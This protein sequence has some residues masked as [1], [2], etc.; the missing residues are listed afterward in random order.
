MKHIFIRT[1]KMILC[2]AL[3][4]PAHRLFAQQATTEITGTV[5]NEKKEVVSDVTVRIEQ[6][7]TFLNTTTNTAGVFVMHG[8][9]PGVAYNLTFS[10]VGYAPKLVAGFIAKPNEKNSILIQMSQIAKSLDEMVIVGYSSQKKVDLTGAV[11][12]VSG[13]VLADRPMPNVARGLQG[14]IPNLNITITD[15]K[16]IRS[17][18]F[19]VRGITS[20]NG[21]SALVL[22][23]G[24]SGDPSLLNP[25]DIESIS[26]LKDAASAAIYGARGS[27][28][29]VLIT[30]KNPKKGKVQVNFN[31]SYTVNQKT[32]DPKLV[33]DGYQWAQAFANAY[34]GWYDYKSSPTTI[35][36][37]LPFPNYYL[38]SLKARSLDP[39]LPKVGIDPATGK[40]IYYGST[41]WYHELY[42]NN[43]YGLDNAISITGSG[44]NSSFLISGRA[45]SQGGIFRYNTDNFD[46]YNLRVKGD[47]NIRPWLTLSDNL[48]FNSYKYT[49]PVPNNGVPV[50]RMMDLS[51]FPVGVM[52]NPDGTLTPSSYQTVGDLST[53]NN[54]TVTKQFYLR[55]T[56]SFKADIIKN[57]LNLK[58]DFTYAYTNNTVDGKYYPVSY[59]PAP[60]VY[61]AS[62]NSSLNKTTG[63]TKYYAANL[64]A[65]AKKR[66]G[67]HNVKLLGGVNIEDSRYETNFVQRDGVLD[68]SL[69]DFSLLN[70][71]NYQVSGGGNEWAVAGF[72]FRGNYDYKDKYLLEVN[73]RYDGSS[74]FPGYSQ[75]GFF[76]SLSL[77]W[78]L[79]RESFM[80]FTSN[81]LDN[82]KL[83]ASVGSLGNGQIPPYKFIQTMGVSQ[84]NNVVLNGAYP[85]YTRMPSVLPTGLTWETST[86]YDAGID[87]SVL[88]DRLSASFD[89]Y[90]RNTTGMFTP[91]Q[92]LPGVFGAGV[93]N[94]NFSDLKTLGWELSLNWKDN[95]NDDLGYSVGVVLSDYKAY[96]TRYNN[97]NGLIPYGNNSNVFYKGQ[98]YGEIWGFAVDGLFTQAQL[99]KAH[100][101]QSYFIVSN[102]NTLMP[103]DLKFKDLNGD[104]AINIGQGTLADHGD[105]KVIGN[106]LPRYAYGINLGM[107][108]KGFAFNA[109]IQGIGHRD[110]WPGADEGNFW[111]Q[112]N[113]TY[114]QV[115]AYMMKNVWSPENPNAYFPRYRGYV[116]QL[117]TRE[118]TPP[119]DRYMQNA[120]YMRLKNLNISWTLPKKW[121]TRASITNARIYISGQ[122]LFTLTPL[123]KYAANIDPEVI[124]GSDPELS[125]GYGNGY[126]YPMLK[127]Y[128]IGLNITL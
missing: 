56:A 60:G 107:N 36:G 117:G 50:W 45:Y 111:G 41:D 92:P 105:L 8:L 81:W 72:F 2:L 102:A 78:I 116:A 123:H 64:Y 19:N 12:Q 11:T 52:Y 4:M 124:D 125:S 87:I 9:K 58:G 24:V 20:I 54:A 106:S 122:N 128:S 95:I 94:G 59:S 84:A 119:D 61:S 96:I 23:D 83:R 100:P 114:N 85:T 27:F 13:E 93:P 109:F 14:V 28:G 68:P 17:P 51:A 77:G 29:V 91:S 44:Q 31:S 37:V 39:S 26:V 88:R 89:Y 82:L 99:D 80:N 3:M 73:G 1:M 15:G 48:D 53:G 108:Y 98:R 22:I 86:T 35:N 71:Q 63:V 21:G 42:K 34:G 70:G 47:I 32:I 5:V 43:G 115:P 57:L 33:T 104:N 127:S 38:D 30:T 112:Y 49:Y 90:R 66:F 110:W 25:N 10:H 16:P 97:P 18:S 118:L 74:R 67:S 126:S 101:D 62:T 113:R 79:S 120:A 65:E 7:G 46:K 40:Y 55:N 76:P 6:N 75:F 121:L 69:P 103:G